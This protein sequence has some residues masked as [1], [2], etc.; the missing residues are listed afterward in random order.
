ME[1]TKS[2]IR[3]WRA[4][5]YWMLAVCFFP[6]AVFTWGVHEYAH[7]LMGGILG[8]EMWITFNQAGPVQG[9][10]D[11]DWHQILIAMAGPIV[12]WVQAVL[13]LFL[14]C[15]S[16]QLW[17]YSFLFLAL[18]MRTVAMIISLVSNPNDEA[19][20]SLL[21]G[22]PVW[23][24]PVIS[25]ALMFALTYVGSRSLKAGWRSN[26]VAYVMASVVT[27]IVVF[28]DQLLFTNN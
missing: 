13:A 26:V 24:V 14:I 15:W 12:T 11:S 19:R 28:S 5:D 20:V 8:Y 17:M 4:F 7:W 6:A 18:W 10:Y 16:R 23:V 27:V 2:G 9:N 1:K 21:I 22:L 3:K 25:V